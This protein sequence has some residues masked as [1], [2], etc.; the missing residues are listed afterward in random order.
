MVLDGA[1]WRDARHISRNTIKG[2]GCARS[3]WR[4]DELRR[5]SARSI[6]G[7]P[8]IIIFK[9]LIEAAERCRISYAVMY[10]VSIIAST[11][12]YLHRKQQKAERVVQVCRR[13]SGGGFWLRLRHPA[14]EEAAGGWSCASD[15]PAP[16]PRTRRAGR[17]HGERR[18][19][20]QTCLNV[21]PMPVIACQIHRT[22]VRLKTRR[23]SN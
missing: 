21:R 4:A 8:L 13:F 19:C 6:I 20:A 9:V 14:L 11:L 7:M 10:S 1:S 5:Y 16:S 2:I 3:A 18:G 15:S 12:Y 17:S 22:R 23:G